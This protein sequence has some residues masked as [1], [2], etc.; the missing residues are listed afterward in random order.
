MNKFKLITLPLAADI[1]FADTWSAWAKK[2]IKASNP[3]QEF[4]KGFINDIS[5]IETRFNTGENKPQAFT[6]HTDEKT[7]EKF[8]KSVTKDFSAS[9]DTPIRIF[10]SYGDALNVKSSIIIHST[11]LGTPTEVKAWV[12]S[13]WFIDVGL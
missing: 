13:H 11:P 5:A 4:A 12:D 1:S 7:F 9:A 8:A 2:N 6:I 10:R 3:A